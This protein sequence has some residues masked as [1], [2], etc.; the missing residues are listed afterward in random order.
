M[1][2]SH[3]S[4]FLKRLL[5]GNRR[6]RQRRHFI[7]S[8]QQ[9]LE[10]RCLLSGAPLGPGLISV[11]DTEVVEGIPTA[12]I[13]IQRDTW[14]SDNDLDARIP[15]LLLMT[16]GSAK[17]GGDYREFGVKGVLE[18]GETSVTVPIG[19]LNDAVAEGLEEFSYSVE[20]LPNEVISTQPTW[21]SQS[22]RQSGGT[23]ANSLA[24]GDFDGD[25]NT[26]AA[27][28]HLDSGTVTIQRNTTPATNL[29]TSFV[30][31]NTLRPG[32]IANGIR[33]VTTADVNNDNKLD[34]IAAA[35]VKE[36]TVDGVYVW[37]N[38]STVGAI[39]FG[40]PR[41][42]ETAAEPRDVEAG[43]FNGDGRLD[44][45]VACH[46]TGVV[47]LL[48]NLTTSGATTPSFATRESRAVGSGAFAL[49]LADIDRD[50]RLDAITGNFES[51]TF[52][53]VRNTTSSG[54]TSFSASITTL[55][56]AS[57][58]RD[59]LV[60]DFNK[61]GN[62]DLAVAGA[63]TGI[64][65]IHAGQHATGS[66]VFS[67]SV[68]YSLGGSLRGLAVVNSNVDTFSDL[69]VTDYV[70][71]RLISLRNLS[72]TASRSIVFDA[73]DVYATGSAPL[74]I[75]IGDLN[76]DSKLDVMCVN[77]A[78]NTLTTLLNTSEQSHYLL[79]RSGKA[80]IDDDDRP[81]LEVP[82]FEVDALEGELVEIPFFV[83]DQQG[84]ETIQVVS[85]VGIV[86]YDATT[87]EGIVAWR[88]P[89]GSTEQ[90]VILRAIETDG[91]RY[92]VSASVTVHVSN[93][94]PELIPEFDLVEAVEELAV[95][96]GIVIDQN[97]DQLTMGAS[98]GTITR[99]GDT[100]TWTLDTQTLEPGE[101]EIEVWAKDPE[102]AR[103]TASFQM[104][105]P[106]RNEAP[107]AQDESFVIYSGQSLWGN[108]L[109]ND[110]DPEGD[111]LV[112]TLESLPENGLVALQSNGSFQYLANPG[113]IGPDS[114][115]YR[116]TDRQGATATAVAWIDV[117]APRSTELYLT[118]E[119]LQLTLETPDANSC[120]L[121]LQDLSHDRDVDPQVT[122]IAIGPESSTP[123]PEDPAYDFTG[124]A[125]GKP[126]FWLP[127]DP[128]LPLP[129]LSL[130]AGQLEL[131]T[132]LRV[133]SVTG[134]GDAALWIETDEGP[135]VLLS[136]DQGLGPNQQWDIPS[137]TLQRWNLSFT[138]A[139]H[140]EITVLP[141]GIDEFGQE[142]LGAVQSLRFTVNT[143][144]PPAPVLT[145]STG[146]AT[147]RE[148]GLPVPV[149]GKITLQMG[150]GSSPRRL[151]VS[152]GP[153]NHPDDRLRVLSASKVSPLIRVDEDSILFQ[154]SPLATVRGGV[155]GVPLQFEFDSLATEAGVR[156]L[157][158]AIAFDHA[159]DNPGSTPRRIDWE[160]LDSQGRYSDIVSRQVL[161]TPV[162]D[163]TVV[164]LDAS[165]PTY[166][167]NASPLMIYPELT[168]TDVDSP[169]FNGGNV[170]I[171]IAS[172][173]KGDLLTLVPGVASGHQVAISNGL[174]Q[175]DG[176]TVA[177]VTGTLPY[178]TF[179]LQMNQAATP[180]LM[181]AVLRR[182]AFYNN[183]D[184]PT[185]V[186]RSV[187]LSFS[188]GD[189]GRTNAPSR[190][191]A[192]EVINDA[193]VLLNFGASLQTRALGSAIVVAGGL[194]VND[195]DS[196]DFDGGQLVVSLPRGA[197]NSDLLTIRHVGT[198]AGQVGVSGDSVTYGGV[199]VA[200]FEAL[201]QGQSLV[202]TFNAKATA[203]VVQ[204]VGRQV[205]FRATAA[206]ALRSS[207][208][209][210]FILSDGDGQT[211]LAVEKELDVL[212]SA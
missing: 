148:N 12:D 114:F 203:S 181:E 106:E 104:V 103:G 144:L 102:G 86:Q 140:Y 195:A 130:Q 200:S 46:G 39:S 77:H 126:L 160:L 117:S 170:K 190:R 89:A 64:L 68:E 168:L 185:S 36:T 88:A 147:Y 92:E 179:T 48:R 135:Q 107:R 101:Y 201:N 75:R 210:R 72:D 204:A 19:I 169:D 34:L 131:I 161:V 52:S 96:T 84:P 55:P 118:R 44:I 205:Q 188:D 61:D 132:G 146:A 141:V 5:V 206:T 175:V 57:G 194:V 109:G 164:T 56:T 150:P 17:Q 11:M 16:P 173:R 100:W 49:T 81:A 208:T 105:V 83:T 176:V 33:G 18:F 128:V 177:S 187:L 67:P 155:G 158:L 38:T 174:V 74:D 157:A 59:L 166:V 78:S 121:R 3:V 1:L 69:I 8:V 29:T 136:T 43:D 116:L 193:P 95:N 82:V 13:E 2:L 21:K 31:S 172:P 110:V 97:L 73:A 182:V 199:V 145:L 22:S 94:A 79:R 165:R 138:N 4:V 14:A 60:G 51:N 163:A 142:V 167:E 137:E 186:E 124:V 125:A 50:G 25:G 20:I 66:I 139:G 47:T 90:E 65:K 80:T 26:D 85:N 207:R 93:V 212:P 133:I 191:I 149:T 28:G 45:W 127:A 40:S 62:L 6:A 37:L 178:A 123:R 134:P 71:N 162:N 151:T 23:A 113:Y 35:D 189:G 119:R 209:L 99:S 10:C 70:G 154:E 112:L 30:L 159:G 98:R 196:T 58:P 42:F 7:H 108:V 192:V 122:S 115:V 171:T 24:L 27:V 15:F 180:S 111:P 184:N 202:I 152:V 143:P 211:G 183:G 153:L 76:R 198:L 63:N 197:L 120:N 9:A 129:Q 87:G 156:A 91:S 32:G 53:V 54:A 41:F